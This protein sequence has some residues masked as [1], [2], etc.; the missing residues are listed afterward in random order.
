[1]S[2]GV[3]HFPNTPADGEMPVSA[4]VN[5]GLAVENAVA[6]VEQKR[7]E[8]EA[9]FGNLRTSRDVEDIGDGHEDI[10]EANGV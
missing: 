2:R 6:A 4:M 1:M 7:G 5:D 3:D 9:I 8:T 10:S